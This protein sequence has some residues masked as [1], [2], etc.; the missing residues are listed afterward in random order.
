M[1]G[2]VAPVDNGWSL[3]VRPAAPPTTIATGARH[4]PVAACRGQSEPPFRAD[5]DR[6]HRHAC[7]AMHAGCGPV[8]RWCRI[9]GHALVE[10]LEDRVLEPPGPLLIASAWSSTLKIDPAKSVFRQAKCRISADPRLP[11]RGSSR[12]AAWRVFRRVLPIW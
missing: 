10:Y 9:L 2:I 1:A 7:P 4:D 6:H 11:P 3:V 5:A 8:E 12:R